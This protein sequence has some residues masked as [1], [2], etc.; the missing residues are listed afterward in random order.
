M[1]NEARA[2]VT[3]IGADDYGYDHRNRLTDKDTDD[4]LAYDPSGRLLEED[5]S[6]VTWFTYAGSQMIAERTTSGT[7]LRRYV[8]GP[9]VDEPLVWFEGSATGT[10]NRHHLAADERGSIIAVM[11]FVDN[12]INNY[13]PSDGGL[14]AQAENKSDHP[15]RSG[16]TVYQP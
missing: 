8:H 3:A 10:L 12:E 1:T 9:G 15:F 16:F 7:V 11:D 2:N 4:T 6:A 14:A 5:G 13:T